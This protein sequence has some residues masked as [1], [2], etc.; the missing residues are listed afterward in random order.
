MLGWLFPSRVH[1]PLYVSQSAL[2]AD[3]S[4]A[5]RIPNRDHHPDTTRTHMDTD[6]NYPT[7]SQPNP[8]SNLDA[9]LHRDTI[10]TVPHTQNFHTLS[11]LKARWYAVYSQGYT[12]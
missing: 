5:I 6:S 7:N 9:G 1:Q 10:L 11:N 12:N 8:T 2:T 4:R 3:P